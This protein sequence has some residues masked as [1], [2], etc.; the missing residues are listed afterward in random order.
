[1]EVFRFKLK[2]VHGFLGKGF[3]IKFHKYPLSCSGGFPAFK[4]WTDRQMNGGAFGLN[5]INIPSAGTHP[6]NC[7]VWYQ[8]ILFPKATASTRSTAWAT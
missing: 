2:I 8:H 6:G 7:F 3:R 4:L 1:M 5:V